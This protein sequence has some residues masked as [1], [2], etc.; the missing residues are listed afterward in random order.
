ML[1][2]IFSNLANG[3]HA[4]GLN[5]E[6]ANNA[7]V[8]YTT[9]TELRLELPTVTGTDSRGVALRAMAAL[10]ADETYAGK[11]QAINK[12]RERPDRPR[13]DGASMA[14]N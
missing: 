3:N 13:D 1:P 5:E 2:A 12:Q 4:F 10:Q 6:R 14:L 9:A 11:I 8:L 7:A